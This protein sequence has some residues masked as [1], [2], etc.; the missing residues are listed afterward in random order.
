[1]EAARVMQGEGPSGLSGAKEKWPFGKSAKEV[2]PDKEV[3]RRRNDGPPSAERLR[4]PGDGTYPVT[5]L[6]M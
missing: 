4:Q 6:T 1:M 2:I 3:S 5:P